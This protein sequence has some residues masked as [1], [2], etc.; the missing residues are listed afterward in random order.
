MSLPIVLEISLGLIFIYLTLSLIASEIQEIISTLFQWRAEHLKYSIE[1]LLAGSNT[2]DNALARK[3]AD[4]LYDSPLIRNLNYEAQGPIARLARRSLHGLGRIYRF[5]TRSRNIFNQQTSGPSYIPSETFAA[6]LLEN[7]QLEQLQR[8]VSESRL[9]RMIQERISLPV[10]NIVNDLKAS[11]GD[12][13][14]LNAE[15]RHFESTL[16]HIFADYQ[17]RRVTLAQTLDRIL[18]QLEDFAEQSRQILPANHHLSTTFLRR[19]Q[20]LRSNLASKLDTAEI[21]LKQIQPT[22]QELMLILDNKSR[23]YREVV[24]MASQDGGLA[25]QVLDRLAETKIPPQLQASLANLA[26][27]AQLKADNTTANLVQF[28]VEIEQWFN[29]AMDR[30]GGVYKRNSRVVGL[31]LGLAIAL[32]LNADTFHMVGRLSVDQA[33]RN[34]VVQTANQLDFD[35]TNLSI[36]EDQPTTSSPAAAIPPNTPPATLPDTPAAANAEQFTQDLKSLSDAVNRT[37]EDYPLPIGH[38]ET[39]RAS[40]TEAEANWPL[41][42]PRRWLGW[43]ITGIAI[44]MGSN[45]WFDALRRMVSIRSAGG[46]P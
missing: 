10:N 27:Q 3:L 23:L 29:R 13:S 42:I 15:L 38:S 5:F 12:E 36:N 24:Q 22:L 9:K 40:Q 1:Q 46:K 28:Q 32:G 20:Y 8:L 14:I 11:L 4:Q 26:E 7:L 37:L 45:F 21:L 34:S 2:R 18:A 44:S 6:S 16:G 17:A 43:L 31:L 19:L 41:P 35:A 33:V 30:A 25:G 39:V